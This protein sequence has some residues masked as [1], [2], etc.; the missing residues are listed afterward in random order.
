MAPPGG[1]RVTHAD[2][3]PHGSH[4]VCLPVPEE[5]DRAVQ[6][7]L[8]DCPAPRVVP[9]VAP[10]LHETIGVLGLDQVDRAGVVTVLQGLQAVSPRACSQRHTYIRGPVC[11]LAK[12]HLH[13]FTMASGSSLHFARGHF[14]KLSA[15]WGAP[16]PS[17]QP[18]GKTGPVL[19]MT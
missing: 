18:F 10:H 12:L 5:V 8:D 13:P 3:P 9:L 1:G 19:F 4:L 15:P 2:R 14:L 17:F 11:H 6:A 16:D 7:P